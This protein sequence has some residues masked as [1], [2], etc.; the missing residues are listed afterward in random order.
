MTNLQLTKYRDRLPQ[1]DDATLFSP[2]AAL[3]TT[4]IFH[5]GFDLPMFAPSR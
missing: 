5:D 4:L 2:T 1:L 3:E